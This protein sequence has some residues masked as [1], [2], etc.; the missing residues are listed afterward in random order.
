[1]R[2]FGAVQYFT[3][4]IILVMGVAIYVAR[5]FPF[6][7]AIYPIFAATIVIGACI[8]SLARHLMGKSI[9]GGAI[10]IES[11]TSM[12]RSEKLRKSAKAFGWIIGLYLLIALLGF[13]LGALL[14]IVVFIKSEARSSWPLTFSLALLA[15]VILVTFQSVLNVFWPEGLL[16]YSISESVPWLF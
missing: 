3:L 8:A 16:G 14:F 12:D 6:L 7:A 11:D 15:L 1:M 13:K 9:E 4:F 2:S 10:D 5:D